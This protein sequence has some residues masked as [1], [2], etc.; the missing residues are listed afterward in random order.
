MKN[1]AIL[2]L[3]IAILGIATYFFFQKKNPYLS[4]LKRFVP[5]NTLLLLETNE[6]RDNTESHVFAQIPLLSRVENQF[7]LL[8]KIGL[9]KEE[10]QDLIKDKTLYFAL[11]PEAKED[12]N[13]ITY[14][15]LNQSDSALV[16]KIK[17]LQENISGSRIIYHTTRG[18]RIAEVIDS[19][20]K[21]VLSFFIQNDIIIFSSSSILIEEAILP[22]ENSWI[23]EISD[24]LTPQTDS[25]ITATH[26]NKQAIARFINKISVDKSKIA[27]Q[28]VNLLSDSFTGFQS[29]ES[30]IKSFGVLKDANLFEGQSPR[31]LE[32]LSMI[33]N[34]SS[35]LLHIPFDNTAKLEESLQQYFS[36]NKELNILRNTVK[37][38]FK[39]NFSDIYQNLEGEILLTGFDEGDETFNGKAL[40]LRNKL[41]FDILKKTSVEVSKEKNANV[42]SVEYGGYTIKSLGI[43]EFPTMLFGEYFAGFEECYFTEYK[44]YLIITNSLSAM[45]SYLLAISKGDVWSNSAKNQAL[46]KKAKASNLTLISETNRALLGFKKSL[47][48]A[49]ANKFAENESQ[50]NRITLSIFE[51]LQGKTELRLFKNISLVESSKK[52]SNKWIKLASIQIDSSSKPF[53]FTNPSTKKQETFV[54]GTDNQIHYVKAGKKVWSYQL[55]GRIVGEIKNVKIL[56]NNQQQL[57]MASA[58]KVYILSKNTQGFEVKTIPNNTGLAIHDFIIFDAENDKK[59]NLTLFSSNSASFKIDKTSLTLSVHFKPKNGAPHILPITTVIIKGVE[60]AILLDKKGKL[61]LQDASGNVANGFPITLNRTFND[62]A[63]L[64]GSNE[65]IHIKVLSENG[66]LFSVNLS[67]KIVEK[68]Q[69]LR[70]NFESKFF[71][72]ADQRNTDWVIMRSDGKDVTVIDK[73]EREMFTIKEETFGVKRLKYY[74][75]GVGG[76][77]FALTNSYT[78]YRFFDEN[79]SYVG[80]MPINSTYHPVLTYSESYQKLIIDITTPA[81]LEN[82]SVKLR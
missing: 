78:T 5:D 16:S 57:L 58:N 62:P 73:S 27:K 52:Y 48:N 76:K 54:Q 8:Q 10:I 82:W 60:Y 23:K 56:P 14:L 4:T 34:T 45:Q 49:W 7:Y 26:F 67:G 70:P 40:I 75:L 17:R 41:L 36:K 19:S 25:T 71:L 22:S 80:G 11:L 74:N 29:D 59:Q 79:G 39:L 1:K 32:D 2:F 69:L 44:N 21:S 35:F 28:F 24:A 3:A 63:L 64:E 18:Q 61:T 66:E 65:R 6:M 53:Y 12:L 15:P 51:V 37:A 81:A 20:T 30:V 38:A 13:Y 31:K 9:S 43:R 72:C 42:V 33:P 50:L 55:S 77:Y 46:A 47:V 68:K